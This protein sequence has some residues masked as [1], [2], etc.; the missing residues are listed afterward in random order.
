V[1]RA[2]NGSGAGCGQDD[3]EVALAE[4]GERAGR[5]EDEALIG[6]D[7]IAEVLEVG[8]RG[9]CWGGER[10]HGNERNNGDEETFHRVPPYVPVARQP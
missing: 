9:R 6:K 5:I 10:K 2:F 4:S 1:V 8:R 3:G 7:R